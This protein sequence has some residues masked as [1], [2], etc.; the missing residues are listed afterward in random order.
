MSNN[1][2]GR[3]NSAPKPAGHLL[4]LARQHGR[5]AGESQT[6][7]AARVYR[8]L[9]TWQENASKPY[10][11]PLMLEAYLRVSGQ[12]STDQTWVDWKHL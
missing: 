12:I 3:R 7:A 8:G 5:F 4:E 11:D 6:K 2:P 1:H 10:C 9:R